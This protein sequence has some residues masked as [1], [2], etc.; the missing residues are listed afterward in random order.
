MAGTTRAAATKSTTSRRRYAA[1]EKSAIACSDHIHSAARRSCTI[2]GRASVAMECC[3]A[4]P[5]PAGLTAAAA[6]SMITRIRS[7]VAT[8]PASS[9]V[10]QYF[11]LR[12]QKSELRA[13]DDRFTNREQ[14]P[15]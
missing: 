7:A 2:T 12:L 3:T 9:F 11:Q 5:D 14:N 6:I 1:P 8:V 15:S 10:L 4:R 13:T